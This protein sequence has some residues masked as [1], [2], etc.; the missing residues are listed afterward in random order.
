MSC[1]TCYNSG[2]HFEVTPQKK[3]CLWPN[4]QQCQKFQGPGPASKGEGICDYCCGKGFRG[5]PLPLVRN[6]GNLKFEYTPDGE[7]WKKCGKFSNCTGITTNKKPACY[8]PGG[9]R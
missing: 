4:S 9:V 8:T 2:F 3:C 1:D 5:R 7:R 6:N